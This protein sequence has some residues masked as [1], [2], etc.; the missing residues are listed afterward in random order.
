MLRILTRT[1]CQCQWWFLQQVLPHYRT[2]H[3]QQ[4]GKIPE[5]ESCTYTKQKKV[6]RN[7]MKPCQINVFRRVFIIPRVQQPVNALPRQKLS[8]GCVQFPSSLSSTCR[9]EILCKHTGQCLLRSPCQKFIH[10]NINYI[11][12]KT[13]TL[14]YR[15]LSFLLCLSVPWPGLACVHS[16]PIGKSDSEIFTSMF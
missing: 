14:A 5:M 6:L 12:Y 4:T 15:A 9:N 10:T 1:P 16:F 13:E 2:I 11:H 8:S 3:K 7:E